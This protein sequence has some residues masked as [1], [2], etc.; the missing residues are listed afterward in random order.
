[1]FAK[2]KQNTGSTE[3][4]VFGQCFIFYAFDLGFSINLSQ[5]GSLISEAQEVTKFR[6]IQKAPQYFNYDPAPLTIVRKTAQVLIGTTKYASVDTVGLTVFDFGALSIC[7]SVEVAGTLDD[8]INLSSAL[9]DNPELAGEA[10]K[11]AEELAQQIRP[12]ILRPD[13]S[14]LSE[15]YFLFHLAR[16][17]SPQNPDK[18]LSSEKLKLA[19]I[20]RCE[21]AELANDQISDSL[22]TYLS[23]TTQDLVLIDWNGAIVFSENAD[24]LRAVCEFA[25]V[26]LLE[27]RYLDKQLDDAIDVANQSTN[28]RYRSKSQMNRIGELQVDSILLFE[29][30]NNA[31]KLLGD[32]YLARIYNLFARRFHLTDWDLSILR[33]LETLDNIY[34]KFSDRQAQY[35][36]ELLEIIIILLIAF[37]VIM[38]FVR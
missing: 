25:N 2:Q 9:Y 37:E 30:V 13:F 35:R 17:E 19:Q 12:A 18:I 6:R 20:L 38:S 29:S 8:L 7:F 23:Y 31:L 16:W 14:S 1:M 36:A 34:Q 33:K 4:T 26:E 24:D 10:R 3:L 22:S 11:H 21:S 5:C 15:D 28:L 32:Q 27:M